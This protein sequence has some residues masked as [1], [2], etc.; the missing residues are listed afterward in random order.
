MQL[1]SCW[2]SGAMLFVT[3]LHI[4]HRSSK[5]K[6]EKLARPLGECHLDTTV[7]FI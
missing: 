7:N 3:M 5:K 1:V 2:G 4:F 6:T